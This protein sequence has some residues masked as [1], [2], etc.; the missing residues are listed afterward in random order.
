MPIPLP[1]I[2][3][4]VHSPCRCS[5]LY[6]QSFPD[7]GFWSMPQDGGFGGAR[8]GVFF[9]ELGAGGP[10]VCVP[11]MALFP[12]CVPTMVTLGGGLGGAP[13]PP[14]GFNDP[15]DALV[16]GPA[17]RVPGAPLK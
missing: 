17:H 3:C 13:P 7:C 16:P 4:G 12:L 5:H 10:K 15:E 9:F 6:I 2:A 8:E 1:T 11:T 14:V